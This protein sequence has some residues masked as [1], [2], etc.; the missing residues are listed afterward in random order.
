MTPLI[1]VRTV[2]AP[3]APRGSRGVV[4]WLCTSNPF[5]VISAGLFLMGL[6]LSF[7]GQGGEPGTWGLMSG[8]AG[9][10][11]LLAV[12]ACL[13]VRFGNVWDD[14][15]TVLLLV[16]L[17][18][19]ATSI[20]FDE[21]LV[22]N[23]AQGIACSVWGLVFAVAMSEGLLR[24][25]RLRLPPWFRFSY[26]LILGLFFLYPLALSPFLAD[27]HSEA[28]QWGLFGFSSVAG[29][30][31]LTLLPAIRHGPEYVRNNGSPWRWPLYPWA[32]FGLLALAVPARAFLLC[33]SM[34]LLGAANHDQ[35]I[36][37]P[38]FLVPFGLSLAVLLLE[39]AIVSGIRSVLGIA[40]AAPLGLIA[41]TLIGHRDDPIYRGFLDLFT[42][43]LGG[44][45]LHLALLASAGFYAYAALRRVPLAAEALTGA[46][47]VLAIIGPDTLRMGER[48]SPL[49]LPILAAALLQLGL[50]A[51][52]RSSWRCL[53]GAG[54]MVLAAALVLP[55]SIEDSLLATLIVYHL[56]MVA[57][58]GIAAMFDD[59]LA[60][61]LRIFGSALVLEACL[62]VLFG[63]IEPLRRFPAWLI[64]AYVP[65]M[66]LLLISYGLLLRYR[67]AQGAG[68]LALGSW[69]AVVGWAAY[70]DLRERVMGLDQ[71]VLSLAVF[72]LAV[73]VSLAKSGRLSRWL[74]ARG[75]IIPRSSA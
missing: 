38:W 46:L 71:I 61:F 20:T 60:R 50:G 31:F 32:L 2:S 73:V 30:I 19:L 48:V 45:P 66:A 22:L 34:H 54:G 47:A 10:T 49:P 39:I 42:A 41:L 27:P 68:G 53:I 25:T 63:D 62:A 33:W 1:D 69:L 44:E 3:P 52:R 23:P 18:F 37:A 59:A 4:R 36:F 40:L 21:V 5:Y 26:Y 28:L 14:V 6:W 17:M 55:Q 72:V 7:G 57:V 12:T 15:R 65:L 8:L 74:I 56:A 29:L 51:W 9:Y 11:L 43:R 16:V 13:L 75:W 58:L 24:G 64:S 70:R 35:L 67:P